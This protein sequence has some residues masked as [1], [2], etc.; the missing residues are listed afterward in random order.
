[1]NILLRLLG[2][3]IIVPIC[4]IKAFS[5][6]LEHV[7]E[8]KNYDISNHYILTQ[9][10]KEVISQS[11]VEDTH[12][13]IYT[14]NTFK[15]ENYVMLSISRH[16]ILLNSNGEYTGYFKVGNDTVVVYGD[17]LLNLRYSTKPKIIKLRTKDY[18]PMTYDP[19]TWLYHIKN[20]RYAIY[21]DSIGWIWRN[22]DTKNR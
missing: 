20:Y 22:Q 11:Q 4:T 10:I 19:P 2:L 13:C 18:P 5:N 3:L 16:E 8:L 6:N 12:N 14:M 21:N 17:N 7:I 1:M 9:I 15:I